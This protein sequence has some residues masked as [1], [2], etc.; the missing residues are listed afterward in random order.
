MKSEK[1]SDSKMNMRNLW[2]WLA[3]AFLILHFSTLISCTSI[4]CPVQNNVSTY[5]ALYKADGEPDTLG[6]DTIWF[7]TERADGKDTLLN[8]LFG[9]KA[10]EFSLPISYTQPEDV[11]CLALDDTTTLYIDT[12][13]IKKENIPHFESVDCQAAYFHTITDVSVTHHI[14]DSIVINNPHVNYDSNTT[15]FKLYLKARH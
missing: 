6:V 7:W 12:I 5:Y 11:I 10:T 8:R 13:R 15:H 14:V 1:L 3:T 9:S 2:E 4:D